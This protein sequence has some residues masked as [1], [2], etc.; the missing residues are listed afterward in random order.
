MEP[1]ERPFDMVLPKKKYCNPEPLTWYLGHDLILS[2]F[3][4]NMLAYLLEELTGFLNLTD[5]LLNDVLFLNLH[6]KVE[7]CR[8]ELT[9]VLLPQLGT[10]NDV[11][12]KNT[13]ARHLLD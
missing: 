13:C 9:S 4:N 10:S 12:T 5:I 1:L 11:L 8:G 6:P 3:L 7:F 2:N